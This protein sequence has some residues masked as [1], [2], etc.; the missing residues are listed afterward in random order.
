[1]DGFEANDGIIVVAATNRPD[2][3]DPALLRPGRFDRQV[4]VDLPDLRAE[5]KYLKCI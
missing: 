4:V 1:M 3:L 2:V 5:N